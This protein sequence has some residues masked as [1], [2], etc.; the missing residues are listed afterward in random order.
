MKHVRLLC[1]YMEVG[2]PQ[3]GEVIRLGGVTH[4]VSKRPQQI[5]TMS[6]DQKK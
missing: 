2:E 4:M 1:D 3:V 5:Y 6:D